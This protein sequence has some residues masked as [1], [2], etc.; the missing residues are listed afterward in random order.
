MKRKVLSVLSTL[1]VLAMVSGFAGEAFASTQVEVLNPANQPPNTEPFTLG[2]C[3]ATTGACTTNPL[4][5]GSEYTITIGTLNGVTWYGTILF[6]TLG[7]ANVK[8]TNENAVGGKSIVVSAHTGYAS[9]C[10]EN[11]YIPFTVPAG[12]QWSTSFPVGCE[13]DINVAS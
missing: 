13:L 3:N 9:A 6:T 11:P 4:A 7:D 8:I 10:S 12:A 1:A 5:V 2:V